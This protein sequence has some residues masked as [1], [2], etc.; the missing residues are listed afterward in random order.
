MSLSYVPTTSQDESLSMSPNHLHHDATNT[1]NNNNHSP[2]IPSLSEFPNQEIQQS[3]HTNTDSEF[4]SSYATNT[5]REI[6]EIYKNS[7]SHHYEQF[8]SQFLTIFEW[9]HRHR[10]LLLEGDKLEILH[11]LLF[12]LIF[13]VGCFV[14]ALMLAPFYSMIFEF[15]K[16]TKNSV[17]VTYRALRQNLPTMTQE[18]VSRS[19]L[20]VV[21]SGAVKMNL[22]HTLYAGISTE[23]D[24]EQLIHL[25]KDIQKMEGEERGERTRVPEFREKLPK[26]NIF[27]KYFIS[28]ARPVKLAGSKVLPKSIWKCF[29][30]G[31]DDTFLSK[32]SKRSFYTVSHKSHKQSAASIRTNIFPL[33]HQIGEEFPFKSHQESDTSSQSLKRD[34]MI[35]LAFQERNRDKR[36]QNSEE[37][38]EQDSHLVSYESLLS[39]EDSKI[40]RVISLQHMIDDLL[41]DAELQVENVL[42]HPKLTFD[43]KQST[44]QALMNHYLD[45]EK[46]R[47]NY[48]PGGFMIPYQKI[49]IQNFVT[50]SPQDLKIEK[51]L[52]SSFPIAP[53]FLNDTLHL[54]SIS[55][56]L[57][58]SDDVL[59]NNFVL[60]MYQLNKESLFIQVKGKTKMMLFDPFHNQM[61][62][63]R[64]KI[65][66]WKIENDKVDGR[67]VYS[68]LDP[69]NLIENE[70]KSFLSDA[71]ALTVEVDQ[72]EVLYVPAFWWILE[73]GIHSKT[74]ENI[75][76]ML[77]QEFETHHAM[78]NVFMNGLLRH[79]QEQD[80]EQ[81]LLVETQKRPVKLPSMDV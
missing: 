74:E 16:N 54:R 55:M 52:K 69:F 23:R 59:K 57:S 64:A 7:T 62:E 41:T 67:L 29:K 48:V 27:F 81:A 79:V 19:I 70:K 9:Y 25:D 56:R 28:N 17:D 68:S 12:I 15:H 33:L 58:Y 8:H 2:S 5:P 21:K 24:D 36:S 39:K 18:F 73:V 32:I 22:D 47:T 37:N 4:D 31:W 50:S 61:M 10:N 38:N 42:Q 44:W 65:M 71:I 49:Y 72:H 40:E 6:R 75:N 78:L 30:T 77:R 13:S 11:A 60:P 66:D 53:S 34:E 20:D 43:W 26:S 45:Y 14:G 63:P 76:L 46:L 51:F 3:L 1:N 80:E 35:Q